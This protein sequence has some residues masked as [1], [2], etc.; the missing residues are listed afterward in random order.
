K[1]IGENLKQ[2]QRIIRE[3]ELALAQWRA[4]LSHP[5]SDAEIDRWRLEELEYLQNVGEENECDLRIA[6]YV[7][8]LEN[9]DAAQNAV[10]KMR[11]TIDL[12]QYPI[13]SGKLSKEAEAAA[14]AKE[15]ERQALQHRLY[16]CMGAADDT[17]RLA[18][19][20]ERWKPA[21]EQ[22]RT[23]LRY[24]QTRGFKRVVNKLEGLVVQRLTELGK[25]NLAGTGYK[26]RQHI[27]HNLSKRS[28]TIRNA[29]AKYNE[30]APKQ[31]PP[32]PRIEYSDI[33]SYAYL[34]EFELLKY[35]K[36]AILERPWS[37][38]TN[39]QMADKHHKIA[40]AKEEVIRST[41]E[42]RRLR[43]RVDEEDAT[44]RLAIARHSAAD[45]LLAAELTWVYARQLRV[46]NVHRA[47]LRKIYAQPDFGYSYASDGAAFALAEGMG[48]SIEGR[49]GGGD[50]AGLLGGIDE[51]DSLNDEALRLG[52]F[53]EHVTN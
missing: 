1:F 39:R 2:A 10:N 44:Y 38:P 8:A 19:I 6:A 28:E 5:P 7:E 52:D 33:V 16:A 29:L 48:D 40:R 50:E 42:A 25:A 31:D 51:D 9:L 21:D 17:E 4:T 22:Y 12:V 45:P 43:H 26:L 47:R 15:A 11:L 13:N 53:M 35:S 3:G 34:G 46:N 36:H 20:T 18:G 37:T 49:T 41:V 30:L 27:S 32:R 24:V 14:R 23:A